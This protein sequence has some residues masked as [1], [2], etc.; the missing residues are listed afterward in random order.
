MDA[1]LLRINDVVKSSVELLHKSVPKNVEIVTNLAEGLPAT[2][3]DMGQVQQVI[4]NMVVNACDAMPE[5]GRIVIET[6]VEGEGG[7][8]EAVGG[9][10]KL[11]VSDTGCGI[12]TTAQ[13]KIFDPFFTTKETGKGTGL[14]LYIAHAIVTNHGGYINVYSEQGKGTRFNIYLPVVRTEGVD[15]SGDPLELTGSGVVLVIDD[16]GDVRELCRDMLEPLGYTVL[17]AES[18]MSGVHLFRE[19]KDEIGMV[20]LDVIMPKMSGREVFQALKTIR[21]G[22]KVLICSGYSKEGY[23]GINQLLSQGAVGF[24]QKPFSRSAI[25]AAVKA[26]MTA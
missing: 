10:I 24:V 22:V 3:G 8:S 25:A 20:I 17:L 6:S 14:G 18:G 23:G 11:S 21:P 4:I 7:G 13:N 5:G 9:V 2:R 26:A 12:D 15:G 19:R 16:E 1:R